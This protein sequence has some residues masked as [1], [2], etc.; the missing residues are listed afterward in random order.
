[1]DYSEISF[2]PYRREV[3][4][5]TMV[6]IWLRVCISGTTSVSNEG[7]VQ[8][9]TF[10]IDWDHLD[11]KSEGNS[12][13]VPNMDSCDPNCG[14]FI[15][16]SSGVCSG[17]NEGINRIRQDCQDKEVDNKQERECVYSGTSLAC[18]E[19]NNTKDTDC[20]M[21][22]TYSCKDVECRDCFSLVSGC[23]VCEA[24]R[25]TVTDPHSK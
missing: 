6:L 20:D 2:I 25:K 23:V 9:E 7:P 12:Q 3:L 17:L 10:L 18:S 22:S 5:S 13:V 1:M 14:N 4:D 19:C 11:R 24:L 8:C 15:S 16:Q 21:R